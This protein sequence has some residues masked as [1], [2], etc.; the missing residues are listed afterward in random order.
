MSEKYKISN[1]DKLHF[2]TFAVVYW[3]DVFTRQQYREIVIDSLKFCQKEKG[4]VVSA[5]CLMSNHIHLIIGT[6][7]D[8]NIEDIVRDFKKFTSVHICRAIEDNYRES[9]RQWMLDL[10]RKAAHES[11]KHQKYQFW[12]NQYH[13]IILDTNEVLDQ[14]LEYVHDNPVR[15]GIVDTPEEYLYSSARDYYTNKKGLIE[16]QFIE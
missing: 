15:A 6:K 3:V 10:F 9:R 16:L 7:G 4:L 13:P 5:W 1:Q 2:I 14:K 8:N 11:G 12:Q